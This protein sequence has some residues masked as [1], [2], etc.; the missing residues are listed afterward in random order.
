SPA[1]TPVDL[2]GTSS[3]DP[4]GGPLEYAWFEVSAGNVRP[5]GTG[6][7]VAPLFSLGPHALLL[8]VENAI[9]LVATARFEVTVVDTTPP[10]ATAT[11]RPDLLWPPDDRLVPVRI[12]IDASDR[13]SATSS[14][15]LE[16]AVSSALDDAPEPV[17]WQ[18]LG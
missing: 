6:A 7:R 4:S 3:A 2:D 8:Q 13:C 14:V 17:G 1:G 11:A 12:T 18:T 16:A 10:L 5:I 9:G 15:I